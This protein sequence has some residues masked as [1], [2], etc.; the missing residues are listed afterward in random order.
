MTVLLGM[1][2]LSVDA[3][4]MYDTRNRLYA[5][6]DAAA[7]LGA[8]EVLRDSSISQTD[9]ETF[10]H[11]QVTAHG[12]T[13]GT[14][15]STTVGI[16]AVCVNHPPL[17]G[18]F[19]G[20]ASYVEV[21]VSQTTST[22]FG[23]VLGFASMVPGARAVAGSSSP[24][25]CLITTGTPGSVPVSLQIGNSQLVLN[26]CGVSDSGDLAGT[27]PNAAITGNPLPSVGTVGTCS[28]TC[29]GMGSLTQHTATPVD[30]LAG[31][32]L[33]SVGGACIPGNTPT[34]NPGCYSSISS[35]VTTLTTGIYKITGPVDIGNLT[36]N[37]VLLFLTGAGRLTANN[38]KELHLTAMTASPPYTGI[39]IFQ[40]PSDSLNFATGNSFL[41][42][43]SG[44]IYMP[45][46]DVDFPNGLTFVDSGCSLFIAKSLNI[47]N[48]SGNF[49]NG[50]CAS[51]FGG[52]S[53]LSFAV[54]E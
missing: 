10:A 2:A 30:P 26:G 36:G 49:G 1:A 46:T 14:C 15:G 17:N 23:H 54:A 43:V 29:G 31:L 45:G 18:P 35:A 8:A 9:L 32:A 24:T 40:D 7:K 41:L 53:F 11:Q 38:N 6:A 28:G 20:Q 34:L 5:A 50:N 13:P 44:A 25:A 42:D 33:P 21:L 3:S 19:A 16:S 37:G 27:N 51:A 22:F 39:A 12:L 47:R 52:A 4:F 48:G